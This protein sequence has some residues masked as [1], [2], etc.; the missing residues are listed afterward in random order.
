MSEDPG[1]ILLHQ[2]IEQHLIE[3]ERLFP[4]NYQLTFIARNI[5]RSDAGVI[6]TKDEKEK[7][8][9]AI[10]TTWEKLA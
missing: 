3:L 7:I 6:L 10:E 8:I 4:K 1:L 5:D 2:A 9:E